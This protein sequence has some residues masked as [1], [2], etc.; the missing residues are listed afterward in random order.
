[1]TYEL[2]V[3]CE[4][5]DRPEH[6]VEPAYLMGQF[7][8]RALSG[9]VVFPAVRA[10]EQ[11][12]DELRAA[13]KQVEAAAAVPGLTRLDQAGWDR[14]DVERRR[15]VVESVLD[16]VMVRPSTRSTGNRFDPERLDPVWK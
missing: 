2:R 7:N 16:A 10:L 14:L 6:G 13:R 3:E 5:V 15:A 11:E 12:R 1:M 8:S 4:H 9:E